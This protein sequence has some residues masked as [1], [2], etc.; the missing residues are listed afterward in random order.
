MHLCQICKKSAA[1]VHVTEIVFFP[2]SEPGSPIDAEPTL[3]QKHICDQCA[4]RSKVPYSGV[5]AE[6]KS[7][8]M[9]NMLKESARRVREES[10]L[11]CPECGMTFVE[12]RSKG[13]FGCPRDYEVFKEQIQSLLLRIHNSAR[14]VGR[15]PSRGG[16]E[17][18]QT[19]HLSQLRAQLEKAVRDEAYESAA[20][21]RDQIQQLEAPPE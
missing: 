5:E 9:L 19:E 7:L 16:Q 11:S 8:A 12:F 3:E 18:A 2:V 6:S 20:K 13:R 15:T 1:T 10:A 14:H 4:T 17:P 21:L